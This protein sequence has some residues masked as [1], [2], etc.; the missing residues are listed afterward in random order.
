M[1]SRPSLR[2]TLR[3]LLLLPAAL[4]LLAVLPCALLLV[5]AET[6]GARLVA[7]GGLALALVP[8]LALRRLEGRGSGTAGAA[9]AA[10]AA[11]SLGAAAWRAPPGTGGPQASVRSRYTAEHPYPRLSVANLVPEIDQLEFGSYLMPALDPILD[12][13]GATRVRSLFLSL[14]RPMEADPEYRALGSVMHYAYTDVDSGHLYEYV[15]PRAPGE[16]LPVLLFLHGSLG[17]FKA[18]FY[19]LRRFADAERFILVCPSFGIGDW[20]HDG[21]V[22]AV[23]RARALAIGELQGD[24]ARVVLMGLSNGGT[25]VSRAAARDPRAYA[26]LVFL[27]AVMEPMVLGSDAF[28]AGWKGRPVL[29]IHGA[30]DDRISEP[31]ARRAAA[32]MVALGVRLTTHVYPGE[33]HFLLFSKPDE[34]L[35]DLK[36]FVHAAADGE[37]PIVG[38]SAGGAR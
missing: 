17:N 21:G 16:R 5:T 36:A 37:A 23:E 34:V 19:L 20:S 29:L 2:P 31:Y 18:Y 14:Y 26:G 24:P 38:G 28:T 22:E 7:V 1:S 9:A 15:P 35:A 8:A 27:S 33:D 10:V 25:G 32:L 11:L 30:A 3:A 12:V 4:A 13:R 6:A